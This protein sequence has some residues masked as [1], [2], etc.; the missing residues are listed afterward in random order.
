MSLASD[1]LLGEEQGGFHAAEPIND[2]HNQLKPSQASLTQTTEK[3]V[4]QV[5]DHS[6]PN[7]G[8]LVLDCCKNE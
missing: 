4:I 8:T 6:D 3:I 1:M 7:K 5:T 2:H